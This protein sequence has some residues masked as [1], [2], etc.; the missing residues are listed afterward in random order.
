MSKRDKTILP[1]DR[2]M[3]NSVIIHIVKI[4]NQKPENEQKLL[5]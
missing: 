4:R 1:N 5:A 3:E 2:I